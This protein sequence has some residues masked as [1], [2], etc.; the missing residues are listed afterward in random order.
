MGLLGFKNDPVQ[1]V[2]LCDTQRYTRALADRWGRR[3]KA[4]DTNTANPLNYRQREG[5]QSELPHP[6]ICPLPR[7]SKGR[8]G[9]TIIPGHP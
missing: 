9:I 8:E 2:R 6:P 7:N 3:W 1:R 5:I 4:R